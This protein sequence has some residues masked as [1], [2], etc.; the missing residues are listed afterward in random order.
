MNS[1]DTIFSPMLDRYN[2][3]VNLQ[4]KIDIITKKYTTEMNIL[5]GVIIV[6]KIM[7]ISVYELLRSSKYYLSLKDL[8]EFKFLKHI[9]N[10]AA[11]N[12]RFDFKNQR[13]AGH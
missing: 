2:K 10:G 1:I 13:G 8:E 3:W 9:R 6:G 4:T 12:N 11:H 5:N 7:T